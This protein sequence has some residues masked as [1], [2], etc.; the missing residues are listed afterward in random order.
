MRLIHSGKVPNGKRASYAN[1]TTREKIDSKGNLIRRVRIVYGGDQSNFDGER[2]SSTIDMHT[3]KCMFNALA[4]DSNLASFSGDIADAYLMTTLAD[5][6]YMRMPISLIPMHYRVKLKIDHL[7][8]STS[9]LWEILMG[10][11]GLPQAGR[12]FQIDLVS[13]LILHGYIQSTTTPCLWTHPTKSTKFVIYVDDFYA[14]YDKRKPEDA[15]HLIDI[16]RLKYVFKVDWSAKHFLGFTITQHPTTRNVSISMPGYVAAAIDRLGYKPG[17]PIKSPLAYVPP[18][19]HNSAS[20]QEVTDDSKPLQPDDIKFIEKA[21]GS[22]LYYSNYL[23]NVLFSAVTKV[24][25]QQK[26][27]TIATLA[28]T[29]RFLDY[30][31][32]HPDATIT[33]LPS[34][35]Q[36]HVH[37]DASYLS[38]PQSRS[39]A[40]GYFCLGDPNFQGGAFPPKSSQVNG[41]IAV[42]SKI[43]PTVCASVAEAEYAAMFINAQLAESIRQSLTDLGF[44]QLSTV[45]TYDNEI[46]GKIAKQTCKLKRSKSIAMR[47]HWVRDRV[48]MGHFSLQWQPGAK[49]LADFYTKAHP[50]HHF[51]TMARF[52]VSYPSLLF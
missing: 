46:S 3:V 45:I 18:D 38:E 32:S 9:L 24:A 27:P 19:Y 29:Y 49:N 6:E 40:G 13:H 20:Q 22:F 21:V 11:Y 14:T 48:S 31:A 30:A 12:L 1:P 5:P 8:E 7:P 50:V 35:M 23:D 37:S 26:S 10:I 33:F 4:S 28:A 42:V 39:R 47:Y 41:A 25:T 36:L 44:P 34:N 17:K 2:S 52:F 51:T 15:K 43:I 16:I